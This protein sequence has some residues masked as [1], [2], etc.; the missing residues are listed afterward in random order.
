M[1]SVVAEELVTVLSY[2]TD[3]KPLVEAEKAVDAV[4]EAN[5][6]A[7]ISADKLTAK[8]EKVG[9][10]MQET[11]DKALAL[12]EQ[13]LRLQRQIEATG[14]ATDEQRKEL[15]RL[16]MEEED[17][18]LHAQKL[19]ASQKELQRELKKTREETKRLADEEKK[20]ARAQRDADRERAKAEREAARAAKEAE[21]AQAQF[22][23]SL[24][25]S[26]GEDRRG[27]A[28]G[29][30]RRGK[31]GSFDVAG[32][33]RFGE[34]GAGP[35]GP[36][37]DKTDLK[38]LMSDKLG[39]G[40]KGLTAGAA[41]AS[42]AAVAVA[43]LAAGMVYL[44]SKVFETSAK[45]Q[46][47]RASL[48]TVTGSA[49]NADKQFATI[50]EFA[51]TTPYQ[52]ENAT[53]AFV[54]LKALGLDASNAALTSYGN[55]ASALGKDLNDMIE[56]VADATTGEF[57]RLKEFGIKSS[58][59]GDKVRFTF[60]GVTT[61]VQ[62]DAEAI[63]N[64]LLKI[65]DTEFAGAMERQMDTIGGA[66]SNLEDTFDSFLLR[67]GEGGQMDGLKKTVQDV[68]KLMTT[69]LADALGELQAE[70]TG[71]L[72][73]IVGSIDPKD[74]EG[75]VEGLTVIVKVLRTG[76]QPVLFVLEIMFEMLAGIGRVLGLAAN[77]AQAWI[78]S[79]DLMI[80][81]IKILVSDS[82]LGKIIDLFG[83]G[84]EAAGGFFDS[85]TT[86]IQ[87]AVPITEDLALA[88]N[89]VTDAML[90][91][92]NQA[93]A[94]QGALL[95]LVSGALE[96]KLQ[97][98]GNK[99]ELA[100]DRFV[101]NATVEQLQR[102]RAQGGEIG[103]VADEELQR[104]AEADYDAREE[105]LYQIGGGEK[106]KTKTDAE[107][108]KAIEDAADIEADKAYRTA[109]D[110]GKMS[111]DNAR[112]YA[113][114]IKGQE[115]E[116]L[117]RTYQATGKKPK[118][119]GKGKGKKTKEHGLEKIVKQRAEELGEQAGEREASRL[120]I[121]V[122]E[123]KSTM[124]IEEALEA[125]ETK[126]KDTRDKILRDFYSSGKLPPG[127]RS[128]LQRLT[129]IPSVEQQIGKVA[130]PVIAVNNYRVDARIGVMNVAERGTFSGTAGE[131]AQELMKAID[132][133]L[134][135]HLRD[136]LIDVTQGE[137]Q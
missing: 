64:Y 35:G 72:N 33:A 127:V 63:Q 46:S 8:I 133:R 25:S 96:K 45:F 41:A 88:W 78:R 108:E 132:A 120:T 57:E 68:S 87:E 136:A 80:Q 130:P 77:E 14:K 58:V 11:A 90:G 9:E 99:L 23:S 74:L 102:M 114:V 5:K 54:K 26:F 4:D 27:R 111:P 31:K 128:D 89:N 16:K 21:K 44:G 115:I 122:A 131:N 76:L 121:A 52:V 28:F 118:K 101:Q 84:T 34:A 137:L 61:T 13:K 2:E 10:Q 39:G 59:V 135:L 37:G 66:V 94:T 19:A 86:Q 24:D 49:E 106:F 50:K 92:E 53:R 36:G 18:R 17:A 75:I 123:G 15:H 134:S 98:L 100:G 81:D 124:T 43:A 109:M 51:A 85:L 22:S 12:K 56:A 104:R 7:T 55:T 69:D 65:G 126:R 67:I 91:T 29:K 82:V 97:E 79:L 116:R 40:F 93:K 70:G 47:L 95:A 105:E 117:R 110:S 20:A 38:G 42:A 71:I 129:E 6:S 83:E 3:T 103:K 60:R 112:K 1:S 73:D 62:K 125:G 30:D 48:I 107:T 113:T 119:K 32:K